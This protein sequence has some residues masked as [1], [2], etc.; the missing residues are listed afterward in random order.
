[1]VFQFFTLAALF[2]CFMKTAL[3]KR[4]LQTVTE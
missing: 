2:M 1:M 3:V 4:E